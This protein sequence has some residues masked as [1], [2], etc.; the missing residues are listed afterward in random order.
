MRSRIGK[1]IN[2]LAANLEEN[3]TLVK[4][5]WAVYPAGAIDPVTQSKTG[6]PVEESICVRAFLHFPEPAN[7]TGVQ[8]FNEIERGDCIADFHQD[9]PLDGK[10]KL[11]FIFLTNEGEPIDGQKWVAKPTSEKLTQTWGAVVRGQRLMRTVLLRK[12]T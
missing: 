9:T 12:A 4:V 2:R 5:T 7:N 11:E 6:T 3:G 1:I 10:D 8:Q